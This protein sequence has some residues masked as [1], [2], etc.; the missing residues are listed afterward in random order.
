MS[1][2]EPE[3]DQPSGGYA[4]GGEEMA[5]VSMLEL[6]NVLLKR[7]KV[8]AGLPIAAAFIVA[9][10]SLIV[11]EKFTATTTFVPETESQDLN[12]PSGLM[13]LA[14]QFGVALPRTGGGSSPKFYAD[15]LRSRTLSDAVLLARFPE[16]RSVAPDDSAT[17]LELLK[18][19]GETES[20]LLEN[21]RAK[22]EKATSVA[23]DDE[24]SVVSLSV[25]TRYRALSADVA[26]LYI[27]LLN[28]FNLETRQS[29]AEERRRFIEDRVGEAEAELRAAEDELEQFLTRNR[30]FAGSPELQF[31]YERYE[32]RV[33]LKQEVL[34]ELNRQ[35]EEARIQEVNDT[36]V[37]TV[38]DQ[39][40]PPE[41]KSS[42]KRKLNVILA[43]VLGGV[44]SVMGAFTLEFVDRAQARDREGYDEFASRWA[45]MRAELR[46][47][48][49]RRR[50]REP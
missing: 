4:P 37:I 35:Y 48:F 34:A 45:A 9:I 3:R 29:N 30:Q 42:P 26:N 17:L 25:K 21:G 23:V 50:S 47:L 18:V 13:G 24:T 7:W 5:E 1:S 11:P 27:T 39:A 41:K 12:L 44:V 40:V 46:G 16:P 2:L 22:L 8:V 6:I 36:P 49:S 19:K 20:G 38:I 31:Q 28:R 33:T 10:V 32:R 15:V 14:A 43:F